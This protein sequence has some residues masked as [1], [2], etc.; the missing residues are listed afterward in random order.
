MDMVERIS[1]NY[2]LM[3]KMISDKPAKHYEAYQRLCSPL[4]DDDPLEDDDE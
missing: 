2:E 1:P 4:I 3:L